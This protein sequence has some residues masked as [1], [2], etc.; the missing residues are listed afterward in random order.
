MLKEE[1]I[2]K[3]IAIFNGRYDYNLLGNVK[4]KKEK[5]P[6]ICPEHGI[7]YKDYD[8]HIRRQQGCPEC[9]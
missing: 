8:H 3:G 7:F 6:I 5:F 2:N 1:I 4:T 9:V